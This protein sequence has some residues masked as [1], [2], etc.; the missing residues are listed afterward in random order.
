MGALDELKQLLATEAIEVAFQ[1]I[2]DITGGGVLGYEAL[3]R[4]PARSGLRSPLDLIT[5]AARQGH[6]FE[7]E[8]VALR[9]AVAEFARQGTDGRL[10]LNL[11]PRAV[12]RFGRG[13]D[14]TLAYLEQHGITPSRIVLEVTE[15][16]PIGDYDVTRETLNHFRRLGFACA[17]D[18]VGAGYSGLRHLNELR[19]DFVKIDRHFIESMG[20]DDRKRRLVEFIQ[21]AAYNLGCDVIAEGVESADELRVLREIGIPYAQGYLFARPAPHC[22][23]PVVIPDGGRIAGTPLDADCAGAVMHRIP[24][25]RADAPA[26]DVAERFEA[27]STLQALAVVDAR[28]APVGLITRRRLQGRL[29]LA[30]G[31]ALAAR[32]AVLEFADEPVVAPTTQRL[33]S[34]SRR[35]TETPELVGDEAFIVVDERGR[36]AGLGT[37]VDLL[38]RMTDLRVEAARYANPLSGMPGNVPIDHRVT[39]YLRNGRPFVLAHFDIDGF[40]SYNDRY[41]YAAGDDVL[42]FLARLIGTHIHPD[43]D[44]AGHVGGDDYVVMFRTADWAERCRQLLTRFDEQAPSFYSA[45]DRAA[46]GFTGCNREGAPVRHPLISLSI[47]AVPAPAGRFQVHHELAHAASEVKCRAKQMAGS[48]LFIDRRG[49]GLAALGDALGAAGVTITG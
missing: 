9:R 3:M 17:V 6:L 4:G 29:S 1:P 14:R 2:M 12:A 23:Q 27:S 43:D 37:L 21:N 28:G 5:V 45:A 30:Y 24:P 10:F 44:F 48:Q 35:I 26:H 18:D 7:L 31:R 33:D 49:G 47:G 32:K 38:R 34:L 13:G 40:K 8:R 11:T 46:G 22:T 16:Q 20:A 15:I 42:R 19:P 36:Y 25:V 41:G 39:E